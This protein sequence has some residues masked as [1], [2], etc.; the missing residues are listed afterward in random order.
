MAWEFSS[1]ALVHMLDALDARGLYVSAH[2]ADPG[3]TGTNEVTGGSY[4]RQALTYNT[5]SGTGGTASMTLSASPSIP[6]PGTPTTVSYL[7]IWDHVSNTTQANYM[8]RV[9]IGDE[10]FSSDGNLEVTTL[11][12]SL[13]LVPA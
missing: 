7:G 11:T 1:E 10:T 8:G 6:I 5:A 12:L 2:T 13:D 4:A 9:D 3:T